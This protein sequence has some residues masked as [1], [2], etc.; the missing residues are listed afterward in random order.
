[1]ILTRTK[2]GFTLLELLVVI[3]MIGLI[4]GAM[5]TSVARAQ[6]RAR[7][8]KAR[9]EVKIITQAILAYENY[10]KDHKLKE[11]T[12]SVVDASSLGDIFGEGVSGLSGEKIPSL[13]N[14]AM[15][16][17]GAMRDPWGTPYRVT[18]KKKNIKPEHTDHL[19]K[20]GF[21]FPNL[22]RLSR[23]ERQ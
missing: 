16:S 19:Q 6:Q 22:Y 14:I 21:F 12:D 10:A 11:M 13:I 23:E 15:K 7:I 18:I 4:V 1:M 5:S 2:S 3:A 8:E 17:G 9:S 20:T